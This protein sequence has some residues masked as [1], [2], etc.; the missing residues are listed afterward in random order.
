MIASHCLKVQG[1]LIAPFNAQRLPELKKL[2]E[3]DVSLSLAEYGI[4]VLVREMEIPIPESMFEYFT[5]NRVITVYSID[6][7]QYISEP[8]F[9][10][11]VPKDTLMEVIGAYRYWQKNT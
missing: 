6:I 5:N 11:E 8:A 9:S 1:G 3:D 10:V 2:K 4:C 7:D